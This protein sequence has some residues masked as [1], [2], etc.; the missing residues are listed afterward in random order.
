MALILLAVIAALFASPAQAAC[1]NPSG[2]LAVVVSLAPECIGACEEVC[3]PLSEAINVF[4]TGGGE[5]DI[6]KTVCQNQAAFA[7][8]VAPENLAKCSDV[9]SQAGGMGF[10]VPRTAAALSVGCGAMA[11]VQLDTKAGS[12]ETTTAAVAT[13]TAAAAS[14]G[15]R[16]HASAATMAAALTAAMLRLA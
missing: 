9:L 1:G 14:G 16:A 5:A 8:L 6:A 10:K 12:N 11:G 15:L 2:L 7:C 4:S 3:E 13:T